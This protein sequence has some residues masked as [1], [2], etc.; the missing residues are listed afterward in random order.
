MKCFHSLSQCF[1]HIKDTLLRKITHQIVTKTLVNNQNRLHYC[2]ST[3]EKSP[4]IS[5]MA[6]DTSYSSLTKGSTGAEFRDLRS[7]FG[8]QLLL[9]AYYRDDFIYQIEDWEPVIIFGVS[10]M[11]DCSKWTTANVCERIS[12]MPS[13]EG[14]LSINLKMCAC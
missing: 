2:S 5:K 8:S 9:R 7:L 12:T 1:V 6:W 3:R 13:I 4:S 11:V 10:V 14:E